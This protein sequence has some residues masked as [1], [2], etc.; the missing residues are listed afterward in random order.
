M[1]LFFPIPAGG[2]NSDQLKAELA[3]AG[4][5]VSMVFVEN[6]QLAVS[7]NNLDEQVC[8]QVIDAHV[9]VVPR[10]LRPVDDIFQDLLALT[11]QQQLAVYNHL[12][13][14]DPAT[15][16]ARWRASNSETVWSTASMVEFLTNNAQRRALTVAVAF[17]VREFPGFLVHPSWRPDINVPGDRPVGGA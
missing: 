17:F 6:D 2:F 14:S 13:G 3:A 15:G 5:D 1:V 7:G 16:R 9:P 4:Q 12:T 10:E 11:Q 8:Q